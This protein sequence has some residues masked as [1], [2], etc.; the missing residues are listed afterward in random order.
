MKIFKNYGLIPLS[1]T[2]TA[3]RYNNPPG[4]T[5]FFLNKTLSMLL[6]VFKIYL[7]LVRQR[8]KKKG[9]DEERYDKAAIYCNSKINIKVKVYDLI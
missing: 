1:C 5:L 4:I 2:Q 3:Q 9:K 8:E 7:Q 6:M